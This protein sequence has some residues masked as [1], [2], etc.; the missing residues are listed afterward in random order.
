MGKVGYGLPTFAGKVEVR[1]YGANILELA[2]LL[3]KGVL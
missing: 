1:N 3:E 2:K